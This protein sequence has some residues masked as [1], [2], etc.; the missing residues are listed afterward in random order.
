M[1]QHS[2][3]KD[4]TWTTTLRVKCLEV[5]RQRPF[6]QAAYQFGPNFSSSCTGRLLATESRP[7]CQEKPPPAYRY[8][9]LF[10]W[11]RILLPEEILCPDRGFAD[12]R[13]SAHRNSRMMACLA[14][15]LLEIAL[16]AQPCL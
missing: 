3:Y 8:L 14:G 1:Q 15:C 5:D 12:L 4:T 11:L 9:K 16:K 13:K 2:P 7:C 10:G 6:K